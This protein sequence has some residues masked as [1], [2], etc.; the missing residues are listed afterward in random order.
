MAQINEAGYN[1]I[2]TPT[3]IAFIRKLVYAC[4]SY[5][6]YTAQKYLSDDVVWWARVVSPSGMRGMIFFEQVF[7]ESLDGEGK[8]TI[9]Y[10]RKEIDK[11]TNFNTSDDGL[12]NK[13]Q[14]KKYLFHLYVRLAVLYNSLFGG[15]FYVFNRRTVMHK[16]ATDRQAFVDY[17]VLSIFPKWDKVIT[18]ATLAHYVSLSGL[19]DNNQ[20]RITLLDTTFEQLMKSVQKWGP[21]TYLYEKASQFIT[22]IGPV[23][24]YT[25]IEPDRIKTILEQAL[26]SSADMI[27]DILAHLLY[28]EKFMKNTFGDFAPRMAVNF[29]Q[30]IK[31]IGAVPRHL[32]AFFNNGNNIQNL[33]DQWSNRTK[34]SAHKLL[35]F[36]IRAISIVRQ[37]LRQRGTL[38]SFYTHITE[39][40][41]EQMKVDN[42]TFVYPTRVEFNDE[43]AVRI[44]FLEGKICYVQK[45]DL[46]AL[47]YKLKPHM[48][49]GN[50]YNG[51]V[52]A[53]DDPNVVIKLTDFFTEAE[54][55]VQR[56][57]GEVGIGPKTYGIYHIKNAKMYERGREHFVDVSLIVSE[58]MDSTLESLMAK[59]RS[60]EECKAYLDAVIAMLYS[61]TAAGNFVHHDMKP[62]NV[63]LINGGN[64]TNPRD[65][66]VIDYGFV[67]YGGTEYNSTAVIPYDN[68]EPY[69]W[70]HHTL[71]LESPIL[72][73]NGWIRTAPPGY[74]KTWDVFTMLFYILLFF[75]HKGDKKI[76]WAVDDHAK[77]LLR[78]LA[79][80]DPMTYSVTGD[81]QMKI[82][83]FV[84]DD[85]DRYSRIFDIK[86]F[87]GNEEWLVARS[88]HEL[89]NRQGDARNRLFVP[90]SFLDEHSITFIRY[91]GRSFDSDNVYATSVDGNDYAQT[92]FSVRDDL[93]VHDVELQMASFLANVGVPVVFMKHTEMP[94]IVE[95]AFKTLTTKEF[96]V[97]TIMAEGRSS[98]DIL[99]ELARSAFLANVREE[100][101]NYINN[102][103]EFVDV[104][105]RAGFIHHS[106]TIHDIY[107]DQEVG[108]FY[109]RN[110]RNVWY[111]GRTRDVDY[112]RIFINRDETKP[113]IFTVNEK[114]A[115]QTPQYSLNAALLFLSFHRDFIFTKLKE[116]DRRLEASIGMYLRGT[117]Y[118]KFVQVHSNDVERAVFV[119]DSTII[120]KYLYD[121]FDGSR[122]QD[123]L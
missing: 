68:S 99:S 94:L 116:L 51:A 123:D 64:P 46:E 27:A 101:R 87:L 108:K 109:L 26:P 60:A 3:L 16:V 53:T 2:S 9:K 84:V 72:V 74:I 4:R 117:I 76:G 66:R 62:D 105:S 49:L 115:M 10:S 37:I 59:S 52:F 111:N 77:V 14:L 55:N 17:E 103:F 89:D 92:K 29:R 113:H 31:Q 41:L 102:L 18:V 1:S 35:Q 15:S 5:A 82:E 6:T 12:T 98:F 34:V 43:T 100:M 25:Q 20:R 67:W 106:L 32:I 78:Q 86:N 107:Y 23:P 50:G 65:W 13:Q 110:F 58:R 30:I 61:V 75:E 22:R 97:T 38:V 83:I 36:N 11:Y 90:N 57:A 119:N 42:S 69:G 91:V 85:L 120:I 96:Q 54:Y 93:C 48:M 45:S 73:Y 104:F 44:D 19:P 122:R 7:K 8:G 47:P 33:F 95:T 112:H 70:N 121:S 88:F 71:T 28:N 39:N 63:M 118:E 81:V 21:D 24:D 114:F 40:R 80:N 79:D 56:Q